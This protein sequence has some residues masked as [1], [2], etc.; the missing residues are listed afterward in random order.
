MRGFDWAK[1]VKGRKRQLVV[2]TEGFLL[3]CVV[4]PANATERQGAVGLLRET[5]GRLTTIEL[6]WAD[7][8]YEGEA[9]ARWLEESYG[10]SLQ[11]VRP[12][13]EE[14]REGFVVAPRRWV[15]ER[16]IAWL[17]RNRRLRVDYEY[18]PESSKAFIYLAMSRLMLKRLAR[19]SEEE[20]KEAA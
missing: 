2:D 15:V 5:L 7:A 10:V 17:V 19:G 13:E 3:G 8:G 18:L 12:P 4:E 9:L 6:V 20:E 11:I 14:E 16:T 1:K